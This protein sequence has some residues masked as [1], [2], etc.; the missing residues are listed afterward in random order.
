[1]LLTGNLPFRTEVTS[2]RILSS[3]EGGNN[4]AAAASVATIL[5]VIALAVIVLLDVI[6]RRVRP[7]TDTLV[8]PVDGPVPAPAPERTRRPGRR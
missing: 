2:V 4:V 7:V 1:M 8:R 3:I 5:L 6:Q